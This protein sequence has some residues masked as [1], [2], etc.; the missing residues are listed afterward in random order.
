MLKWEG[1]EEEVGN[2]H[3]Y[4]PSAGTVFMS[5]LPPNWFLLMSANSLQNSGLHLRRKFRYGVVS[6]VGE[7]RKTTIPIFLHFFAHVIRSHALSLAPK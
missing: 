2:F 5:T 3:K 7:G 4:Y 6:F 1:L